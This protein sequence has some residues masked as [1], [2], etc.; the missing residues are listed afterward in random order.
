MLFSHKGEATLH[1]FTKI[2]LSF[3][4][5]S[6]GSKLVCVC[7]CV[8][9]CERERENERQGRRR[10][11]ENRYIDPYLLS[12]VVLPYLGLHLTFLLLFDRGVRHTLLSISGR[13]P[14]LCFCDWL[15]LWLT[16]CV[17][18]RNYCDWL[19]L[20]WVP[21]YIILKCLNVLPV[22]NP[23]DPLL[24]LN[25]H[26]LPTPTHRCLPIYTTGTWRLCQKSIGNIPLNLI[27]QNVHLWIF[28]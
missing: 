15:W 19:L 12:P 11:I 4:Y 25:L 7:V 22:V 26:E 23:Y 16:V 3:L 10:Q 8:C 14:L 20:L 5:F 6:K 28:P 24:A 9:V 21:A 2:L 17:T 27:F 18:E 1:F 13:T